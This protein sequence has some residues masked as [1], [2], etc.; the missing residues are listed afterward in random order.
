MQEEVSGKKKIT[1]KRPLKKGRGL[2][3]GRRI[4]SYRKCAFYKEDRW[5]RDRIRNRHH[6]CIEEGNEAVT[7]SSLCLEQSS[8]PT[9][10][11]TFSNILTLPETWHR[12]YLPVELLDYK[13]HSHSV[14]LVR[15][16]SW[17]L[18]V[19]IHLPVKAVK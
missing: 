12:L 15:Q 17:R 13:T 6:I 11:F 8:H 10:H 14:L 4:H 5:H 9:T 3:I 7:L 18:Y 19:G 16:F 1:K 2:E